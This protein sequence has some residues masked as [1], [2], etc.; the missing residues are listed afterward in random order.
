MSYPHRF[1]IMS[2][3]RD[4][5]VTLFNGGKSLNSIENLV[6]DCYG[7]QAYTR[8]AIQKICKVITD[9][10]DGKDQRR[11]AKPWIRTEANVGRV[12]DLIEADGRL[13]IDELEQETGLSHGTIWRILHYDLGLVIKSARW[14][15]R[16]LTAE[17]KQERV[18]CA[19]AFKNLIFE[20]GNNVLMSII[21]MDET[22]LPEFIPERKI[23]SRQWLPKGSR[24]PV[25][26]KRQE[27]RRKHMVTT[28]FDSQGLVYTN[29]VPPGTSINAERFVDI[30]QKFLKTIKQKR[31]DVEGANSF[32]FHMD[33]A[34]IHTAKVTKDYMAK[35]GFRV[36]EHPPTLQTWPQQTSS[37][38]QR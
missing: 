38:S 11:G 6:N 18:R 9:G 20:G 36:V 2:K 3:Q 23:D 4:F 7:D 5:I 17:Q 21:T 37:S 34:P 25:K 8:R 27:S 33:N 16:L 12:R 13:T 28:F 24:A 15:P 32:L 31:E 19:L 35:K 30:L 26:A 22:P 14:V 29:I 1:F 10:G